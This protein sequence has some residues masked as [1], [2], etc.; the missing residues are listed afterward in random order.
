M[1][2]ELCALHDQVCDGQSSNDGIP[3][4]EKTSTKS[5]RCVLSDGHGII[6]FKESCWAIWA[7]VVI[8][9]VGRLEKCS[10]FQRAVPGQTNNS[11]RNCIFRSPR[12]EAL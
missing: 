9:L 1:A 3:E 10:P 2:T 12:R 7:S 6:R 4:I 8:R 5:N 11:D